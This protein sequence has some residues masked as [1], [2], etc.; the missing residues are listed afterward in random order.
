MKSLYDISKEIKD[1]YEK[2]EN[3]EGIDKETGEVSEEVQNALSISRGELETK[4]VDYGYVIKSFDDEIDIYDKEIKRL[5][6]RKKVMQNAQNRIKEVL[7]NAMIEFGV[8][9]VKGK[10]IEI[11]LRNSESIS[12]ENEDLIAD[13]FKKVKIETVIDKVAI[14]QAIKAGEEVKG[15]SVQKNKNLQ[16]K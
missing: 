2:L 10:T 6:E 12:I 16:I 3:G 1:I 4:A 9:K 15:V 7:K 11:G 13:K 14:K 5:T 8:E